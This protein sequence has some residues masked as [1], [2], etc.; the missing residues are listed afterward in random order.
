MYVYCKWYWRARSRKGVAGIIA[1]V[2]GAARERFL[3]AFH[4]GKVLFFCLQSWPPHAHNLRG[5]GGD[6]TILLCGSFFSSFEIH[7]IRRGIPL[8][9]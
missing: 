7:L 1:V 6:Y 4:H 5:G 3:L 8:T 9:C 2:V